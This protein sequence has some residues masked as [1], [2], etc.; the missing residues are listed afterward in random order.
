MK[1]INKKAYPK[2]VGKNSQKLLEVIKIVKKGKQG[3]QGEAG[4]DALEKSRQERMKANK[5]KLIRALKKFREEKIPL[6]KSELAEAS[7]LSISTLNRSPYKEILSE[8][9]QDEKVLLSPNGKQEI[10][11]LIRENMRLKEEIKT[12]NEMY[13]RLKKEITYSKELF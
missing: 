3:K 4:A 12:L 8:Y 5:K 10:A 11:G 2:E 7:D 9:M 13:F 6:A 1:S